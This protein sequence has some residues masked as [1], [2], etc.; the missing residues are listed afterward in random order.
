MR[1][2][3]SCVWLLS[4]SMFLRFVK[5][6]VAGVTGSSLFMAEYYSTVWKDHVLFVGLS[7]GCTW[8]LSTFWP[9]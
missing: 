1:C 6:G 5:A 9:L 7:V 8:A 3:A 2:V 4:C